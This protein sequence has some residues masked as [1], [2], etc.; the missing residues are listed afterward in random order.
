[1]I[2][3]QTL[4]DFFCSFTSTC[5]SKHDG[6]CFLFLTIP[7]KC[8]TQTS[9]NSLHSVLA[10][11]NRLI[12]VASLSSS[13]TSDHLLQFNSSLIISS[14]NKKRYH[15]ARL[16]SKMKTASPKHRWGVFHLN[17]LE[18]RSLLKNGN[19]STIDEAFFH[20]FHFNPRPPKSRS[21]NVVLFV[22][23]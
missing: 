12:A 15:F 23:D 8:I 16:Q 7:K 21:V 17:H 9:F 4:S 10:F 11:N 2:N 14:S 5:S 6:C 1:M 22:I 20:S 19:N 3:H 18:Y 13:N